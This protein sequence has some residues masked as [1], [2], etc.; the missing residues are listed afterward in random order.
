MPGSAFFIS[1]TVYH[2]DW[3]TV[4]MDTILDRVRTVVRGGFVT[5]AK[6]LNRITGGRLSPNAVTIFGLLMHLPIAWL[7]AHHSYGW[8]G[9]LLIVF[10]LF[11]TLDGALAKVQN[12]QSNLGM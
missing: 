7:I 11:D 6:L 12:S 4:G 3:Y 10:G 1:V 9:V 5:F 2:F 8:A